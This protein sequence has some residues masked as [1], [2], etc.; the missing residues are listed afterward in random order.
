MPKYKERRPEYTAV[1]F[2][3][4]NVGEILD[5]FG[6]RIQT[7]HGRGT[8]DAETLTI[9]YQGNA[10]LIR[11]GHWLLWDEKAPEGYELSVLNEVAFR[12][13]FEAVNKG[14][15]PKKST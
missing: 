11:R 3:G 1:Q 5:E 10:T 15:R 8:V 9:W 13:R 4:S 7:P 14:G 6:P 12:K 2:T